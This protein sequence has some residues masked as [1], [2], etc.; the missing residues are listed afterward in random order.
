MEYTKDWKNP[1]PQS[2]TFRQDQEAVTEVLGILVHAAEALRDQRWKFL[3]QG[4]GCDAQSFPK[5][6]LFWRSGLTFPMLSANLEGLRHLVH[7]SD[8]KELLKPSQIWI[9]N[10]ID[11]YFKS[12]TTLAQDIDPNLET[13]VITS[14]QKAKLDALL[15]DSR[16]LIILFNDD[17]GQALGLTTGFFLFRR[18]LIH[19]DQR[20]RQTQFRK[21]CPDRFP[22][23]AA[24]G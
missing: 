9:V 22:G 1:G 11:V 17:L 6:A 7:A 5:Q 24:T 13:A 21:S 2:A 19:A 16:D 10:S 15:S 18:R 12:L 14:Q 23:H 4:E 8:I 20:D 3:I